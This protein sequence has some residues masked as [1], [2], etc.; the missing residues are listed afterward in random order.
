M[1]Q[2]E[3]EEEVSGRRNETGILLEEEESKDI[4]LQEE[5]EEEVSGRRNET[6]ILLE[7]EESKDIVL[8]EE[9]EEEVSGSR[10]M[11]FLEPAVFG[12]CW[13]LVIPF[14]TDLFPDN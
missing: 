9:E 14:P 8:Q 3:G 11:L 7:E 4:V 5:E 2:E 10:I 13:G 6:G 12:A 1:L